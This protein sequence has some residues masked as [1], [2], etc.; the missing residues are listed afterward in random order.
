MLSHVS[1]RAVALDNA[2]R[3]GV[4]IVPM[5]TFISS[6]PEGYSVLL[7]MFQWCFCM[8]ILLLLPRSLSAN[9]KLIV[10]FLTALTPRLML[11]AQES[12]CQPLATR[13]T[14]L[15][16][17]MGTMVFLAF[18]LRFRRLDYR[19]L[20]LFGL[21]PV[22]LWA[23]AG[24]GHF[25]V[26]QYFLLT[27]AICFFDRKKWGWMFLT[28]GLLTHV[29]VLSLPALLF[30][31]NRENIRY[32]WIGLMALLLPSALHL[33]VFPGENFQMVFGGIPEMILPAKT[34][35][36]ILLVV[37][38]SAG[39]FYFHPAR[40]SRYRNDPVPGCFFLFG[41]IILLAPTFHFWYMGWI[42]PLMV[43]QPSKPWMLLCLTIA[44][45]F[46]ANG[47]YEPAGMRQLP[48][49]AN[50][51]EW[52]PFYALLMLQGVFFL[53][54][55]GNHMAED[56]P[57]TVSVVIPARNEGANIA[58]CV[59]EAL[60]DSA[61]TE[62][63]VVDGGSSD[64]TVA[65]ALLAGAR[66]FEDARS[67]EEGGGRGGQIL[68]GIQRARGDLVAVVHAD[69][70]V[71]APGFTEMCNVLERQPRVCGGALGSR[72]ERGNPWFWLINLANDLRAVLLGISFG[73][74]VQFFRRKSVVSRGLFPD[75]P[76]MEDVE[77]SIRLGTLGPQVFLF[78]NARV[79]TRRWESLGAK[80][81]FW[82]IARVAWY[83]TKRILGTPDTRGMYRSYYGRERIKRS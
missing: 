54:Q 6:L 48:L 36:R 26:I 63:I 20:T 9:R 56:S 51:C 42:V 12:L 57:G 76:L 8:A 37:L 44:F 73:D 14:L 3:F 70:L 77:L 60:K 19:W 16:L 50:L 74:Q 64:E 33:W 55:I 52:V 13:A 81:A 2:L 21:N 15:M 83:L 30:F 17:D 80:N 43:I 82:V 22:I 46:V 39:L 40:S 29:T 34:G 59:G 45:S 10:I 23:F 1:R 78:G 61:V 75:I 38:A 11:L 65:M 47:G 18:V 79:S 62:V 5:T 58:S 35:L 71:K 67:V 4:I 69:T 28:A 27:G 31:I 24:E 49:W 66:V 68:T 7:F 53:K 41:C 25:H 72:F 32:A